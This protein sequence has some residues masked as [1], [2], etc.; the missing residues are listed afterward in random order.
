M[1]EV[2]VETEHKMKR[3]SKSYLSGVIVAVIVVAL[4]ARENLLSSLTASNNLGDLPRE[5][6]LSTELGLISHNQNKSSSFLKKSVT[7]KEF[8]SLTSN[9]MSML[10][11]PNSS[12]N[13]L[14]KS[15]IINSKQLNSKLTRKDTFEILAHLCIDLS[16]HFPL[17]YPNVSARNYND[18]T[19]PGKYAAQAAYLQNRF[20]VNGYSANY[21]GS[22]RNLTARE[23]IYFLYRFYEAVSL[24]IITARDSAPLSFID[25]PNAHP[26]LPGIRNLSAHGAFDTLL[27]RA[28]FDGNSFI[29]D[30]EMKEML[31]GI[32][33][34]KGF[35]F[36]AEKIDKL[37]NK[38]KRNNY[39]TR[40]EFCL[41][42]EYLL[43]TVSRNDLSGLI[44]YKD[45]NSKSREHSALVK[46]AG[47]GIIMGY[48]D[49]TF[50]G[51]ERVTRF[52]VINVLNKIVNIFWRP[53]NQ[54]NSDFKGNY[55]SSFT[56]ESN[57][58]VS[59]DEF[60]N[61]IEVLKAKRDKIREIVGPGKRPSR[62]ES[63]YKRKAQLLGDS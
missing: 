5:L 39:T 22:G 1:N 61:F 12:V 11:H 3:I 41:V 60:L 19:I 51:K 18:Y 34:R 53:F 43:D 14:V 24:D 29:E 59:R 31:F 42:L 28:A 54:N 45:I 2:M 48:G 40:R 38:T 44:S 25:L 13:Y 30:R 16:L 21:L 26:I 57:S 27:L 49:K 46:L 6:R 9:I 50:R 15:Q 37:F 20:I 32:L 10:G 56:G 52:E 8:A 17:Q 62:E 35:T 47:C 36:N 63:F 58:N 4:F 55:K 33:E 7:G 23:M